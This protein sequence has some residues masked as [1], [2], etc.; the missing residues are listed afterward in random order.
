MDATLDFFDF[1]DFFDLPVVGG[2]DSSKLSSETAK[3][4]PAASISGDGSPTPESCLL[5]LLHGDV[6]LC[7]LRDSESCMLWLLLCAVVLC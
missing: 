4:S 1:F 2:P 7:S 5:S 3:P 6:I